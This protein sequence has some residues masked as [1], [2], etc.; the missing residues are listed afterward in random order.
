M[1][2][3]P[4]QQ[5]G[6]G[7]QKSATDSRK[8]EPE[9]DIGT[10]NFDA[11]T[12]EAP[13]ADQESRGD[14]KGKG[15][16]TDRDREKREREQRRKEQEL[17][18]RMAKEKAEKNKSAPKNILL[19]E[20]ISIANLGT[21]LGVKYEALAK[22]MRT[23]G[24]ENTESDY[25]LPAETASLVVLDY[26][27]NPIV[28]ETE[29]DDLEPRPKPEDWSAFP[30]R[31]PVVTIMGHVDHGKTT[32]LDSLRKTSVAAGE[33]G[34][35]TQHIGAF[36]VLLPSGK[37]ITFLDTPG[38]AAF[39][40][41]RARGAQVTDIVVLV[42]AAD[43]GVMPQT[44]EAIKH[45]LAANV[46][47]I[48]AINK[49]DKPGINLKKAKEGLIRYDIIPEDFGGD[50][51]TVAVS[52]LTGKGLDELEETILTVSEVLDLRGDAEGPC[53]AT[54]IESKLSRERGNVATVLVQRGT[55][56][57]GDVLV[58]GTTWC[59][60]RRLLDENG[61]EL[62]EAGPSMPIEVM[63]WKELPAAGD[64]VLQAESEN[65]AKRVVQDRIRRDEQL[66]SV[67]MIEESNERRS[68]EKQERADMLSGE[69]SKPRETDDSNE[70]ELRLII[71]G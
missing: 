24:F 40:A 4:N 54:I 62:L 65:Q 33:A 38:H 25:V 11:A 53:E 29:I 70:R 44:V 23:L 34:G 5:Q 48:V 8:E 64:L 35:I 14:R 32:L 3:A 61:K 69:A 42:V 22:K 49:C 28:I 60:A 17:E 1:R 12:T 27:M 71:K 6:Q 43:D 13:E 50:V 55:L 26:G 31:P 63:G 16:K 21:L 20:G 7:K 51:P 66:R 18:Q 36:S 56:R 2:A 68:K 52:G 41:M 37:R 10:F 59:K 67:K 15:G 39:S 30:L 57:P 47:I 19:P 45:S 9:F 46:P 58:S